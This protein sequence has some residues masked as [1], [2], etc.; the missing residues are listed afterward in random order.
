VFSDEATFQASG[1]INHRKMRVCTVP[2]ITRP[3]SIRRI[4]RRRTF[5]VQCHRA[6]SKADFFTEN[7]VNEMNCL[8]TL[9]NWLLLQFSTQDKMEL[10][11]IFTGGFTNT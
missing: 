4:C 7:T 5:D 11:L 2:K 10:H 8:D 3:W 9:P 1:K 6:K